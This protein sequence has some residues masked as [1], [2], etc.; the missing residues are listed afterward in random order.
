MTTYRTTDGTKWGAGKGLNLT[1]T[2]VDLNFWEVIARVT[3]LETDGGAA[4]GI[5]NIT[6]AGSQMTIF[7][8]NGSELGPYT[9]PRAVIQYRGAWAAGASYNELDVISAPADGGIYL[10]TTTHVAAATFDAEALSG[11]VKIYQWLFPT[12]ATTIGRLDDVDTT[13]TAP[14]EGDTLVFNA[15]LGMWVPA[16]PAGGTTIA[17]LGD[18]ADV[19]LNAPPT[20]GAHLEY[21]FDGWY[22][23]FPVT[24]IVGMDDYG[25]AATE[26][27]VLTWDDTQQRWE[28]RPTNFNLTIVTSAGLSFSFNFN[29]AGYFYNHTNVNGA[30]IW[31]LPVDLGTASDIPIG[32][33]IRGCRNGTQL[34]RIFANDG[35]LLNGVNLGVCD[36]LT[37]DDEYTITKI[38][39][40]SYRIAKTTTALVT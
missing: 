32:G 5:S 1:A 12:Q 38:A 34:V 11:G 26:G 37:K 27:R 30:A 40:N 20:D 24:T 29:S 22:E 7:L 3:S 39:A 14:V 4:N 19:W 18:V 2:E 33:V 15:A 31:G 6:V 28:P 35:V 23:V 9:L 8:A 13:T 36:L 10:V 16:A 17:T 21:S 25:G